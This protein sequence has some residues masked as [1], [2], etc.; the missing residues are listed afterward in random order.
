VVIEDKAYSLSVH[1][2]KSRQKRVARAAIF[3][4][5]SALPGARVVGGKLVVNITP[6][7][8]PHKGVALQRERERL[9]C[10]TA[11]YVGDDDTDEDVFALDQPGRLLSIRVSK[12]VSSAAAYYIENQSAMDALLRVLVELRRKQGARHHAAE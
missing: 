9:H 6:K 12:K 5:A 10:D 11:I 8:A 3:E 4:A 2:R 1:Y 7:G